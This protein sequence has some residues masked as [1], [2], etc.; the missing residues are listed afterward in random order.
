MCRNDDAYEYI[1]V[2]FEDLTITVKD[3]K[4]IADILVTRYKFKLKG[5]GL[6]SFHLGYDFFHDNTGTLFYAPC[7]YIDKIFSI[8]MRLF[9][10]KTKMNVSSPLDK[11]DHPELDTPE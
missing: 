8:Y 5:T 1:S 9:G 3:P 6:I 11:G 10:T 2:Q 4:Y 7:K